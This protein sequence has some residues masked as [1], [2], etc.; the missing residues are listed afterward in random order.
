MQRSYSVY[1]T[2]LILSP[3]IVVLCSPGFL[4]APASA[5]DQE[6]WVVY[7][8]GEGPGAGSHIVLIAGDEEYRSE[9]ALPQLGKILAERHGFRCTVLFPI[10]PR[11]G[12][13]KPDFNRN[14][15]GTSALSS[16]DLMVIFTRFRSLPYEQMKPIDAYLKRGGPVIGIRPTVVGF[17]YG[18]D[19]PW[20][21]YSNGYDGP[22]D[23]WT[24][25]FGE[26]VLG[27]TWISHHGDHGSESTRGIVPEQALDHPI[28]NGIGRRGIW[29][30]TDV[31]E[32]HPPDRA[33][34]LLRGKVLA[35][36]SPDSEPN[37]SKNDPMMPLAWLTPY[38]LP[39]GEK[40]TCFTTT[41]GAAGDFQNE[42][43]RRLFVNATYHLLDRDVPQT[44][45]VKTVGD[46]QPNGFGFGD[47]E[48]GRTPSFYKPEK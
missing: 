36:M 21:H 16:A 25:G 47:Y 38:Q 3:L 43:L 48:K 2:R 1:V 32:V 39:G 44:A 19:S 31:Y 22:R 13:I 29:G 27:E 6:P 9:E 10:D 5:G 23:A 11:T 8:G 12:R 17:R 24:D 18:P 35:G 41:I 4:F 30:P 7:E 28:T 46:Y 34:I 14:I 15:P 20:A 40:G 37:P 42:D 45:N 33:T 26:V